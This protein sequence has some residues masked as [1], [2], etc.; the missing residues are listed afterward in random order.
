MTTSLFAIEPG[1]LVPG[2]LA[3]AV[4]VAVTSRR[5]LFTGAGQPFGTAPAFAATDLVL[6]YLPDDDGGWVCETVAVNGVDGDG[7][8]SQTGGATFYR[9]E[10]TA[11][12]DVFSLPRPEWLPAMI[13]A[14]RPS[15]VVIPA[16]RSARACARCHGPIVDPE[17][18][19]DGD[20]ALCRAC[21]DTDDDGAPPAEIPPSAAELAYVARLGYDP[22]TFRYRDGTFDA[23]SAD[24]L[25]RQTAHRMAVRAGDD[26]GP[27]PEHTPAEVA[28]TPA[29]QL[30]ALTRRAQ[31]AVERATVTGPG[32]DDHPQALAAAVTELHGVVMALV[33][34]VAQ[35][36]AHSTD[37]T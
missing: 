34:V 36:A 17:N 15:A 6:T 28:L 29:E 2:A 22:E 20:D 23:T 14:H 24:L 12:A 33:A 10:R 27:A 30:A 21:G 26:P 3:V 13:D 5:Y 11:E 25:R 9:P 18:A 19:P 32:T 37:R 16:Q 7:P 31:A 1:D 4:P 35:V 8:W